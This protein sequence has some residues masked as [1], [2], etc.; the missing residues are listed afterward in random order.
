[1]HLYLTNEG[2]HLRIHGVVSG[3]SI[4]Q[5]RF[6]ESGNNPLRC[7]RSLQ[8]RVTGSRQLAKQGVHM[9]RFFGV[10]YYGQ[11]CQPA[12]MGFVIN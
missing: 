7:I 1:M 4:A 10:L 2:H 11:P 9:W 3:Y 6:G 12:R 5:E 8:R